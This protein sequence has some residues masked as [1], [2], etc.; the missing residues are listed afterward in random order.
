[1]NE[2]LHAE[3]LDV[4][5]SDLT[6]S[7]CARVSLAKH[8]TE[9]DAVSDTRL[10]KY[11]AREGHW[12][13]DDQTEI[14]TDSGWKLFSDLTDE[15]LVGQVSGWE[16][17][18]WNMEFVKPGQIHVS[19]YSGPMHKHESSTINYC[20]TPGH[21]MLYQARRSYGYDEWKITASDKLSSSER[22]MRTS[23]TLTQN[24][25]G[26][27]HSGWLY[28][29][30]LADGYRET[31]NRVHVRLKRQRKINALRNCLESLGTS[32]YMRLSPSGVTKFVLT[33][34]H[35]ELAIASKKRMPNLSG[36]SSD[37]LQ[38][39]LY[40]YLEGDGSVKHSGWA[41]SSSS[42][43]LFDGVCYLAALCG[44][45]VSVNNARHFNN[46]N[47]HV[48]YRAHVLS[49]HCGLV[50]KEHKEEV[51]PYA[52]FVYC[53]TVPSGMVMVRRNGTQLVCGNTPF[54]HPQVQ[55]RIKAPIFVARQFFKHTTGTVRSEIS[56]RY[57]DD[58]PTFFLPEEWRSR[59]EGNIKQGSGGP[60]SEET[61]GNAYAQWGYAMASCRE[62]Y[63]NLLAAGVAPEMARMV[64]PQAMITEWVETASLFFWA[65]L[66]KLRLDPHAQQESQDLARQIANHIALLFPVS[67][68]AL[69]ENHDG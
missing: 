44:Y 26:T 35:T 12:C 50:N 46:P 59:P 47:H 22:R 30:L 17:E 57:V 34:S 18:T 6:V 68:A 62:S 25:E 51:V 49:R 45:S 10:I 9:F 27:Y 7:N 43:E 16:N 52:G 29:F 36:K 20:V 66:C 67:W 60:V 5:G 42:K 24:G 40:G 14:I 58:V 38:G 31:R 28:G 64:L 41:F 55:F 37:Y 56:R 13:Y 54:A 1:M 39:M 32:Y 15:D 4:M 8:H 65:R 19:F 33:D 23:A 11:L 48:N 2:G 63:G 3:L 61:A 21:R 53:V 69:M